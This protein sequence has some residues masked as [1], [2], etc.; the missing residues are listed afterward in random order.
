VPTEVRNLAA[1]ELGD[2]RN[3]YREDINSFYVSH[4]TW[5]TLND[6]LAN[7]KY[8]IDNNISLKQFISLNDQIR[9]SDGEIL[10]GKLIKTVS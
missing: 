2:K 1:M 3:E 8:D 7:T 4:H 9:Q 10:F 5:T 6:A